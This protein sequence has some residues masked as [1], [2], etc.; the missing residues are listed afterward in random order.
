MFQFKEPPSCPQNFKKVACG[1][2]VYSFLEL[3]NIKVYYYDT[4]FFISV[5]GPLI[6]K[7]NVSELKSG[8]KCWKV[9][10][11]ELK[12]SIFLLQK[13]CRKWAAKWSCD[14]LV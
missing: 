6:S 4:K 5:S 11:F 2:D 14:L 10:F 8:L 9:C 12:N 13:C 3:P 7:R 1:I